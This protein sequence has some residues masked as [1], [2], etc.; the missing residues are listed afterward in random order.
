LTAPTVGATVSGWFRITADADD[1][2]GVDRVELW[3]GGTRLD[4]DSHGPYTTRAN[5]GRLRSG[6]YTVSARAFDADGEAASEALTVRVA[7][8]GRR[9]SQGSGGWAQLSSSAADGV[10]HLTGQTVRGGDVK[11]SIGACTSGRGAV[12]DQFTLHADQTGRL[13]ATYA[14]SNRCVLRLDPM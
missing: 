5:A 11:V 6:T 12:V 8:S 7:R 9:S 2:K 13:D 14:G 3:L 4:S 1:D 10:T